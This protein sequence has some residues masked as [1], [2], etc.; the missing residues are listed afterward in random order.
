MPGKGR[1][2]GYTSCYEDEDGSTTLSFTGYE[3]LDNK[4]LIV[5]ITMRFLFK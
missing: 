1:D 4:N 3:K 2:F 5:N